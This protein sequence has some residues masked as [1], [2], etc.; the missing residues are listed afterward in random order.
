MAWI[1]LQLVT[2]YRFLG[3]RIRCLK[4]GSSRPLIASLKLVPVLSCS[5][6]AS[7]YFAIITLSYL[8]LQ[9]GFVLSYAHLGPPALIFIN[10]LGDNIYTKD[11]WQP[12]Y[13]FFMLRK[14]SYFN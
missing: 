8:V 9:I 10:R 11:G 2:G 6:L 3:H 5:S 7:L 4:K 13:F 14:Y 12:T 1:I